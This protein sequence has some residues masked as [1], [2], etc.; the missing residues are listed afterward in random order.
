[1]N[2]NTGII[3]TNQQFGQ[4]NNLFD[5]NIGMPTNNSNN[6]LDATGPQTQYSL[7]GMMMG[8]GGGGSVAPS[9]NNLLD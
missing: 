4:S 6:L 5:Q 1:M 7:D 9:A 2:N 3:D 8:G